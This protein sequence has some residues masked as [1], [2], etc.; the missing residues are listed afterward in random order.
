MP[1]N[2]NYHLSVGSASEYDDLIAEILFPKKLGLIV[3]QERGEGIFEISVHSFVKEQANNFDYCKNM[4]QQK[5]A[6]DD[7]IEAI[8][9]ATAELKRLAKK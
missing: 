3:S 2:R 8:E 1:K 9:A 4:E 6:L 7:V 5:V